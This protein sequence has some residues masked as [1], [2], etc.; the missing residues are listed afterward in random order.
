MV[1]HYIFMS[2]SYTKGTRIALHCPYSEGMDINE[3]KSITK[4]IKEAC[5][6]DVAFSTHYIVTDSDEWSSVVSYDPFFEGVYLVKTVDKFVEI[7]S[8]DLKLSGLDI[9]RYILTRRKCTHLEL[10]KLVYLSYADFI[11]KFDDR[12]FEDT[13]YAFK[14]GPVVKSIYDKYKGSREIESEE[15]M[16]P[17][18][19]GYSASKSR[20]LFLP[21]GFKRLVSIDDTL[22]KYGKYTS[23]E[24]VDI[25]HAE[26]SPWRRTDSTKPFEIICDD[27]IKTYHCF[28][29]I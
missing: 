2:S 1:E 7:I 15:C 23:R 17:D 3:V 5:G 16:L 26:G 10:E 24:L 29:R 12:L 18:S 19:A 27:I 6:S 28:E 11:C 25:T 20:I 22:Q 21:D 9:A 8:R 13:I 4:K 14:Y